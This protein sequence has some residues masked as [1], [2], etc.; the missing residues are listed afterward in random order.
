MIPTKSINLKTGEVTNYIDKVNPKMFRIARVNRDLQTE[1][2][3]YFLE[4]YK[5]WEKG[6]KEVTW[7]DLR[8][9][10]K[11][12]NRPTSYFFLT[13]DTKDYKSDYSLIDLFEELQEDLNEFKKE[14]FKRLELCSQVELKDL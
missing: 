3:D 1:E 13:E 12:Y 11:I 8:I 10:S 7:K 5:K 2:L 4:N 14:T 9:I 6:E